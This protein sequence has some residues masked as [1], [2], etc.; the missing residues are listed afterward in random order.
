MRKRVCIIFVLL[1]TGIGL[2]FGDTSEA[3]IRSQLVYRTYAYMGTPYMYGGI[4]G[5]G[6]DCSGLVYR[7][8][9]DVLQKK[10][11]RI[12]SRLYESG[13]EVDESAVKPGDLVFFDTTG[14]VSHVGI[15]VGDQTFIHAASEG[16]VIG[17][18]ESKLT[19]DY[20]KTRYVGARTYLRGIGS[21]SADK[22]FSPFTGTFITGRGKMVITRLDGYG[23]VSGTFSVEGRLGRLW[24]RI[25][26]EG[27]MLA[28]K[29][30][31]PGEYGKAGASGEV[32]FSLSR[33]PGMLDG[34]WRKNGESRW[35]EDW[36]AW[37]Q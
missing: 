22:P 8:Y 33:N 16:R 10:L 17:V 37:K 35:H 24:G 27:E 5:K 23:N 36:D 20:Y 19:Q 29:W 34:M 14:G 25:D 4:S 18:K 28:A 21:S 1:I 3:E 11:P 9:Q 32:R 30:V 13:R 15:Y 2:S 6:V 26:A 7:V 31:L 12:V